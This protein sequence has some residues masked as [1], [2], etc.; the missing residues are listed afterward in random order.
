MR[1]IFLGFGPDLGNEFRVTL[2]MFRVIPHQ[3]VVSISSVPCCVVALHLH[4][5]VPCGGHLDIIAARV[6]ATY[7]IPGCVG[8]GVRLGSVSLSGAGGVWKSRILPLGIEVEKQGFRT[9]WLITGQKFQ[10]VGLK[11]K[12]FILTFRDLSSHLCQIIKRVAGW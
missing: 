8:R 11:L 6:L 2:Q 1:K 12:A 7:L 9:A 10:E 3:Y 5:S 4:V